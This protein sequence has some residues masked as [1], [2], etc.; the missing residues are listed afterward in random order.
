MH[1]DTYDSKCRGEVEQGGKGSSLQCA[2]CCTQARHN[3]TMQES[4]FIGGGGG[5][6]TLFPR[7]WGFVAK[8]PRTCTAASVRRMRPPAR[9]PMPT[10]LRMDA[11][12]VPADE[13]RPEGVPQIPTELTLSQQLL[14]KQYEEQVA[15]MTKTECQE[16]ALEVAR[17]MIVKDNILRTMLK[18]D[19][20]FGIEPPDPRDFFEGEDA[21]ERR[22]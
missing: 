15:R 21:E 13:D 3:S 6:S 8:R 14:M 20:E 7:V 11:S 12:Y 1:I 19:V 17:Q 5:E 10:P 18:K 4:A 16:L 9:A 2:I 22:K